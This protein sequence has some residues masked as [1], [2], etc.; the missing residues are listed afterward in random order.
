MVQRSSALRC[1]PAS[2]VFVGAL[3]QGRQPLYV[4]GTGLRQDVVCAHA[5]AAVPLLQ[6]RR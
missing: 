1:Q 3:R 4:V 2:C 5:R 6:W